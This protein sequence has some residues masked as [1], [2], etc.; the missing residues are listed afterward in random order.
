[1]HT[2]LPDE[3]VKEEEEDFFFGGVGGWLVLLC[4]LFFLFKS[5]RP[6]FC[7]RDNG[8]F[9]QSF[10]LLHSFIHYSFIQSIHII[11]FSFQRD[12]REHTMTDNSSLEY[13]Y[14]MNLDLASPG[15][16]AKSPGEASSP[17]SPQG[18]RVTNPKFEVGE[19]VS[20]LSHGNWYSGTIVGQNQNRTYRVTFDDG[21]KQSAV[22]EDLLKNHSPSPARRASY[23]PNRA[24]S[25]FS[26]PPPPRRGSWSRSHL[27]EI[28]PKSLSGPNERLVA[29]LASV[30]PVSRNGSPPALQITT[31]P[32]S[33]GRNAVDSW[34]S[35]PPGGTSPVAVAAHVDYLGDSMKATETMLRA[36]HFIEMEDEDAS[37]KLAMAAR[38]LSSSPS[39]LGEAARLVDEEDR[40]ALS[41]GAS[42]LD[43]SLAEDF[44]GM[45]TA[46]RDRYLELA[47]EAMRR[48]T[49]RKADAWCRPKSTEGTHHSRKSQRPQVGRGVTV[50]SRQ[51]NALHLS[52]SQVVL[53][54]KSGIKGRDT[55]R[56]HVNE[57]HWSPKRRD[58]LA[59]PSAPTQ[60]VKQYASLTDAKECTFNPKIRQRGANN[61][62]GQGDHDTGE[63]FIY[64]TEAAQ[65]AHLRDLEHRRGELAYQA[66]LDKRSCPGCGA[67]QSYDEVVEKRK[68]CPNCHQEYKK[69]KTWSNVQ[70]A[71]LHRLEEF[72]MRKAQTLAE[73][74]A[75]ARLDGSK[76]MP[77]SWEYIED[78]FVG[79]LEEDLRHRREW[80]ESQ[81]L[82][83]EYTFHPKINSK[84]HDSE[85]ADL[86]FLERTQEDIRRRQAHLAATSSAS[87]LN[88]R[89]VAPRFGSSVHATKSTAW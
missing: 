76:V 82:G 40:G 37:R 69:G 89:S 24:T 23:S 10:I 49:R 36:A 35:P 2:Y 31:P 25:G 50:G 56:N 9:A 63:M 16:G 67:V 83:P 13:S 48:R 6:H 43:R 54:R 18:L 58:R 45:T 70:R 28:S 72:E 62:R 5:A 29:S 68:H 32:H 66:V 4:A 61:P 44:A 55:K 8:I 64:R 34:P 51:A 15:G 85:L 60:G 79:R 81:G 87:V 65:R 46:E 17:T 33:R 30:T 80:L 57:S 59:K 88:E 52:P 12:D 47:L 20:A 73:A 53:L 11:H 38:A 74:E 3:R 75:A 19:R 84:T 86:P 1:M 7:D 14:S 71:F 77:V 26:S 22:S 21:E 39:R 42:K 27:S 41:T 78:E